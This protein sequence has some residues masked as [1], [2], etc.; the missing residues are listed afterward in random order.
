MSHARDAL[1]ESGH[2][3]SVEVN[4]RALIDKVLARYSGEFTVFRELLQN[5]DDAGAKAVEI[6]FE[7]KKF[8][9]RR[10]E[11]ASTDN[12]EITDNRRQRFD[13]KAA[14]VHQWVFKNNGMVF[15]DE[16]WNRLKKIAEGNPDEEKIGAFGV[17]FYS[18]FSVTEEPFVT[19]GGQWMGF[20]WKDKKDQL[21]ARRGNL[22]PGSAQSDPWTAFEMTLREPAPIPRAFDL[23]RFLASS[24]TFMAHL[25]EVSLF[26]DDERISRLT[27]EPGAP[28]PITIPRTLKSTSPRGI[29]QVKE[30]QTTPLSIKAEL[31]RWV[32]MAGSDKPVAPKEISKAPSTGVSG[33]FFSSLLASFAGT[34][35]P[36]RSIT[37]APASTPSEEID[38]TTI[39]VSNVVLSI[40]SAGVSVKLDSKLRADLQRSTKKNPPTNMR[41]ELIYTGKEEYDASKKED[42]K[43][44]GTTGSVFQGLR[45]DI[46][47][48]GAARIF[49]GH[50]TGQTTGIAGHIAARFIPTVERES[51]DL[52]DRT[53]AVWN[54]E[55]LYVGGFLSRAAYQ[56]EMDKIRELWVSAT[57]ADSP[58]GTTPNEELRSFLRGKAIHALQF[59]TFRSSTP[60]SS[61][62]TK[63]EAAFFLCGAKSPFP[64]MSS[65]GVR[66]LQDVRQP[67][68]AFTFLKVLPV[69]DEGLLVGAKDMM[70]ILRDRGMIKMIEFLDVLNELRAR[71]LSESELVACLRWWISIQAQGDP[72]QLARIRTEFI[73]AALLCT[74]LTGGLD[75]KI[76]PLSSIQTFLNTRGLGAS[77]PTDGPLPPHLLPVSISKQFDP[78]KLASS[79]PWKEF[80]VLDWLR[81]VTDPV[82]SALDI[83]HDLT[84]SAQWAERV[85]QVTARS[86]QNMA[87]G[88]KEEAITLLQGKTCVPTTAG[89]KI[90]NEAYFQTAHVF[91]DLPI[92]HMPSETPIKGN[93]EKVMSA[94]GVRK[95]VDLQ[96]VFNRMIKTGDWTI[97]ELIKY[98]VAV[99]GTLTPVE[100]DR[101]RATAAFPKEAA[102]DG[103]S[104]NIKEERKSVRFKASVLYEPLDIYRELQ[105]PVLDWGQ[106]SRWR[107]NSEEAKFMINLGLRRYPPLD[108]ILRLAAG[109]SPKVRHVALQYFLDNLTTKYPD[110]DPAAFGDVAFI[111]AVKEGKDCLLKP[112]DVYANHVWSTL[113]FA[114]IQPHLR[115]DATTKLKIREQPPTSLLV[116]LLERNPPLEESTATQWFA[117]LASRI[118]EFTNAQLKHLS[119]LPFVPVAQEGKTRMLPP[120][121]CYFK[122]D[123]NAQIHSKL[124]VFIDFGTQANA[125]LSAC[126]TKHEPSVEEIAKILLQNP[127]QFFQLADGRNNYLI[128]LR[129]I[130]VNFRSL[131][132]GTVTRMKRAPILLGSRRTQRQS[133]N[134]KPQQTD[135]QYDIEEDDWDYEY[136]LLTPDRVVV[137]VDDTHHYQLFGDSLFTAPQEDLLEDFYRKLG[138]R[139]L[140]SLVREDH[141][142]GVE[143]KI[144]QRTS[145][146]RTLILERLPLFLHERTHTRPKISYSQLNNE[147]NFIV[148]SFGKITIIKTLQFG[149]IRMTKSQDSSAVA[150][151]SSRGP[152][153]LWLAAND[154]VDMYEVSISMCRIIFESYKAS[155]ALLFMTILST[156]LRALRRRGYNVDRI[157]RQQQARREAQEAAEREKA[158]EILSG[159]NSQTP[160][161]SGASDRSYPGSSST[162]TLPGTLPE[163]HLATTS[164]QID[165]TTG[166]LGSPSEGNAM[167]RLSKTPSMMR[168]AVDAFSRKLSGRAGP[169]KPEQ[170]ETQ[171]TLNVE[172]LSRPLSPHV[173]SSSSLGLSGT[174]PRIP[175]SLPMTPQQQ[176]GT[177]TPGI[178]PRSN[179]ET[180]IT[181]AI[182]ACKQ[183]NSQRLQSRENMRLVKETLN[184]GYCDGSGESVDLSLV[185][186]MGTVK[187]FVSRDVTDPQTIMTLKA[188][189][190]ARFIYVILPLCTVYGLPET[191][192]HIYYD[193]SGPRIAFN[194]N[195]SLFLNLR[196]FEAWH[197]QSVQQGDSSE[198]YISW[199]LTLAHEIAHNLVQPHN[200][201][202][203]FYFS[204]ITGQYFTALAQLLT[205]G[206]G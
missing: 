38:P 1:W 112:F 111:P 143:M 184:E 21:F 123:S 164:S 188:D 168:N 56:I 9:D 18:L 142:T 27:K 60:S 137:V 141:R 34:G 150:K 85:L 12:E 2:D 47:G 35:T 175:A 151:S 161:L 80:S 28:K 115:A 13:Q 108:V 70:N 172:D 157:L 158:A 77:I 179:I 51:I 118:T 144:S 200:S 156:D 46:D 7:T 174:I 198:A 181:M 154:Q 92:A 39:V 149:N 50:A 201:E 132:P 204:A 196:Y 167:R 97:A 135:G 32:Y 99:Q 113:G 187:F 8:L 126:G 91:R 102:N 10:G 87:Q 197:D 94:I 125:F 119:E 67:D 93:L 33:G 44:P 66:D 195:A 16:D 122:G 22:P 145:S 5:S 155:D 41:L 64:I 75:E 131:S 3:E 82:S 104:S 110:Y 57:D 140:S 130:A 73:N 180:N 116:G 103:D 89:L 194:R 86:W 203:E 101:L 189:T 15:R 120:S 128:E 76:I 146:I 134:H 173:G 136:D 59:Y 190:I 95:H 199:Y 6:R 121:H 185:G 169:G 163:N 98:L 61:V 90:P 84:K 160:T 11:P 147:K 45:A 159:L 96:I 43:Q 78:A 205:K 17:G 42:E 69:I 63:L 25:S 176:A 127:H 191:S 23:T 171:A 138:A 40:F 65:A 133:V 148:R 58:S 100:M 106:Q 48:T 129:N 202:H 109:E 26:L 152:V 36:Q 29:M 124:F 54:E 165:D 83:E 81:F 31:I 177:S 24:I 19:S 74:T 192:V 182:S 49:I 88:S 4:Q 170:D 71:P 166:Q 30:I 55:L 153:E 37:P 139:P 114:V 183:E 117:V 193:Q 206:R 186:E 20:Y 14:L 105:L 178:T 162:L 52:V 68:P 62:S 72:I 79:F 107:S 53:V